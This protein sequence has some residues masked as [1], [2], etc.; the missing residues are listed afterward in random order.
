ML[1][2]STHLAAALDDNFATTASTGLGLL[3][4]GLH[5]RL[6][7]RSGTGDVLAPFSVEALALLADAQ[8]SGDAVLV[9]AFACARATGVREVSSILAAAIGDDD[10]TGLNALSLPLGSREWRWFESWRHR[11]TSGGRSRGWF[12]CDFFNGNAVR[13]VIAIVLGTFAHRNL[14][15]EI[16]V[17]LAQAGDAGVGL[18][19]ARMEW[20]CERRQA[21]NGCNEWMLEY[22]E[23]S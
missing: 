6:R 7:S 13:S 9:V 23:T 1:L 21:T 10:A 20:K 11:G 15:R 16:L 4:G 2:Q 8:L 18:R 19:K 3:R 5:G 17:T 14:V 12:W 22:V